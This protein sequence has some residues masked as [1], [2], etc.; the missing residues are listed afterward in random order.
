[1]KIKTAK[2]DPKIKKLLGYKISDPDDKVIKAWKR[3][4]SRVC[5]PCWELKY[6]PYGPFV[7][8]FPLLPLTLDEVLDKFDGD[9]SDIPPD[10]YAKEIPKQIAE[11]ACSVF[12]HICPVVFVAESYTETAE[13]RRR[14]RFISRPVAMRVARRDNYDCQ[15]CGK[16]LRDDEIEFD[17]IIPVT[18]GGSSEESNL[19]VT[20]FKCNRDKSSK[21]KF[22]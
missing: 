10:M 21:V 18:K 16:H 11:M 2:V 15:I 14:G 1:L 20:C 19:R 9:I 6:C 8:E 17:H 13:T 4:A 7:E 12:G 3:R 22:K 5:K